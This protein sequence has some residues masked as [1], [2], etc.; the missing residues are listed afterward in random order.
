MDIAYHGLGDLVR[1]DAAAD[2]ELPVWSDYNVLQHRVAR[3]LPAIARAGP[4][5]V[6]LRQVLTQ[7]PSLVDHLPYEGEARPFGAVRPGVHAAVPAPNGALVGHGE[8]ESCQHFTNPCVDEKTLRHRAYFTTL[9]NPVK[10]PCG[11]M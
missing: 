1:A 6:V 2:D 11:K 5:Q 7:R 8:H 3:Y 4:Q 10:S 9:P